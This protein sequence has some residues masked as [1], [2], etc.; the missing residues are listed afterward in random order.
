VGTRKK[1]PADNI[2]VACSRT[3][4][5]EEELKTASVIRKAKHL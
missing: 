5:I 3:G 1:H 4:D 2:V